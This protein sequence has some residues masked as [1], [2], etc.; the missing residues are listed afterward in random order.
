MAGGDMARNDYQRWRDLTIRPFQTLE[1]YEACADFQE[2]IWG[3]GFSEKVS[4][5]ILMIANR[6]GGLAAGAF[7]AGG[8]LQGFVFGL[9]GVADGELVHWSDMLAVRD[10]VRDQ[11]L[12]THLKWYQR[13]VMLERG[14]GEMRWTFDPLQSRNAH[15]NFAKLGIV[16]REYVV[17]MY[18]ITDSPLHR[19][20]D[21]DRL[22]ATWELNSDRVVSRISVSGGAGA[23]NEIEWASVPRV[24]PVA[25]D[26]IHSSPGS[27]VLGIDEPR[28]LVGVPPAVDT[29]IDAVPEL[30]TRWRE[31]TRKVFT[32]YLSRG[33]QVTEFFRTERG[34]FYLLEAFCAEA[35]K[36]GCSDVGAA[37]GENTP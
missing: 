36:A 27:P 17:N 24:L 2:E 12:G 13:R 6:L 28:V 9:T 23:F 29:I 8:T 30:A 20:M 33:Y 14:V 5:A 16:S 1:E 31:A 11:G 21:T 18:G 32:D 7:D 25:S 26:G 22:V 15:V 37:E 10:A 34:S 19:G 3:R 35:S 4:A